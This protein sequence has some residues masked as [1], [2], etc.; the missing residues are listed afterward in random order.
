M[1]LGIRRFRDHLLFEIVAMLA[2]GDDRKPGRGAG[3][4]VG[5]LGFGFTAMRYEFGGHIENP[6]AKLCLRQQ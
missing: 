5:E 1:K 4:N 3:S 6:A 2:F